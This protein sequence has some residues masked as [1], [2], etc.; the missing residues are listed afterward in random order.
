MQKV[1]IKPNQ[2]KVIHNRF[3]NRQNVNAISNNVIQ[4]NHTFYKIKELFRQRFLSIR[5]VECLA[6]NLFNL[7]DYIP[8]SKYTLYLLT[9]TDSGI[10]EGGGGGSSFCSPSRERSDMGC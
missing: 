8:F 4:R 7:N 1:P 2:V 9:F 6:E 5:I 10:F 3:R